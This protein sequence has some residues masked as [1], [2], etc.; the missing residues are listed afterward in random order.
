MVPIQGA[1]RPDDPD[2]P[3]VSGYVSRPACYKSTRQHISFFV[4][5]RWVLSRMLATAVEGAYKTLLL[6]GRH[7][8]AVIN[9]Q[10]DPTLLDVNVHPA[11]T[12]IRFLKERRVFA[13]ILRAVRAALLEE[14]QMPQWQSQQTTHDNTAVSV[15]E[16]PEEELREEDLED[17]AG[18]AQ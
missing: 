6:S 14:P 18:E 13:A 16:A 17:E 7:P 4:N 11:K 5:R 9:I 2:Y 12:E 15:D 1:E 3:R 10:I 8:V